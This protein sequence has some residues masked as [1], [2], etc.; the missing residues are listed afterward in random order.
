MF[1]EPEKESFKIT[2]LLKELQ[3]F[4]FWALEC[5]GSSLRLITPQSF[6]QYLIMMHTQEWCAAVV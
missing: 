3:I 5:N 4:E 6:Y 2:R 1:W